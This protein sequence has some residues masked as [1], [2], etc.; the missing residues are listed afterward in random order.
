MLFPGRGHGKPGY[1]SF[2]SFC[3]PGAAFAGTDVPRFDMAV[4]DTSPT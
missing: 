2:T 3:M 1:E 4:R